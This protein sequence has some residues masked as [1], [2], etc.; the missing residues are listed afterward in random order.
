[1][2]ARAERRK[3][4]HQSSR[5]NVTQFVGSAV[6][7][8][9]CAALITA[10][11]TDTAQAT[12]ISVFAGDV[13]NFGG[14]PGTFAPFDNRS[15]AEVAAIN[16]AANTDRSLTLNGGIPISFGFPNVFFGPLSFAGIRLQTAGIDSSNTYQVTLTTTN[17]TVS[18]GNLPTTN[19]AFGVITASMTVPIAAVGLLINVASAIV[20]ITPLSGDPFV[21]FD[22]AQ[23][24]VDAVPEPSTLGLTGLGVAWALRR[25]RAR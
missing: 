11:L 15:P 4:R 16:G 23:L 3:R 9:G 10:T 13:D 7:I 14:W 5:R 17:G 25:R 24:E 12:P 22:Y 8:A 18:L 21:A 2:N 20:S 6:K 19:L 1:M